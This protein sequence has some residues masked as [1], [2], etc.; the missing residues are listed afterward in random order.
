MLWSFGPSARRDTAWLLESSKEGLAYAWRGAVR[1]D[2]G[3]T[4][5][6]HFEPSKRGA[7]PAPARVRRVTG[8]HDDLVVIACE[9][10][11]PMRPPTMAAAEVCT[12]RARPADAKL[13]AGAVIID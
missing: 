5:Y 3:T 11:G 4:I 10:I 6:L 2:P 9:F 8:V 13:G 1:P 12:K 7:E